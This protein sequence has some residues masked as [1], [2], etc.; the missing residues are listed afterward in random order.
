MQPTSTPA[1]ESAWRAVLDRDGAWDGRLVYGVT[2]TRIFCRPSCPSRRPRRDRVRFFATPAEAA[3]AGFRAC[4]RCRPEGDATSAAEGAVERA[5]RYLD[6][7]PDRRVSLAELSGEA[8]MSSS[9][10]QRT[11]RRIVGLSPRE[12]AAA[13]RSERLRARLRTEHSV[14]RATYEAGYGSSSRVY[15]QAHALL[16]MTP[17]TFR[18]GGAGMEIRFTIVPSAYGRLLVAATD[19]GVAAV[20]LG[21]SD[22]VLIR[23]LAGNFPDAMR[24]RVDDGD[25]W[26]AGLVNAVAAALKRPASSAPIPL[27][28]AGTAFQWRVWQAL[29]T[30]PA[31]ETRTY[32]QLARSLGKPRAVRAVASA[33]AANRLAVVI[34]CHRVI[35][36]D[37]SL[38]GYRWGLPRKAALLERERTRV[39]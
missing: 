29:T 13:R 9:H 12:Y 37:G 27:D 15:E 2:S 3:L 5:R 18:N 22:A 4:K 24:T 36:S 1:F 21:D 17:A 23:E 30:I 39:G 34:P 28:L 6:A 20:A 10:L 38:G 7:H 16:G 25:R 32:Q 14:S 26:L 8:G 31:G 33:C 35:R 19:R 11:F